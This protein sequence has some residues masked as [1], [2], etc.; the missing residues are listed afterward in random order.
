[1]KPSL[2]G[3]KMEIKPASAMGLMPQSES[4]RVLSLIT[5]LLLCA[6]SP[7]GTLVVSFAWRMP[8]LVVLTRILEGPKLGKVASLANVLVTSMVVQPESAQR[9]E[10][11]WPRV[12]LRCIPECM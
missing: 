2:P 8:P 10:Q 3:W 9:K 7:N 4:T 11:M 5:L 1:M 12:W 6:P